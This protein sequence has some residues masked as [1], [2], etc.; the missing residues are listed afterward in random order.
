MSTVKDIFKDSLYCT[1]QSFCVVWHYRAAWII[2]SARFPVSGEVCFRFLFSLSSR[3]FLHNLFVH[4]R[5]S[6]KGW[7]IWF[8]ASFRFISISISTWVVL[9][10][11]CFFLHIFFNAM[12]ASCN[13]RKRKRHA[14]IG[15]CLLAPR[16]RLHHVNSEFYTC[17]LIAYGFISG[18]NFFLFRRHITQQQQQQW[19]Y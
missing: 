18:N 17:N 12:R 4:T 7:I 2:W 13:H 3:L 1:A 19:E 6:L 5:V 11:A 8:R 9:A 16:C 15:L 14:N 10:A